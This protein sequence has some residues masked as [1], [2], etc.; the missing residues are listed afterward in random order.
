MMD[1]KKQL[2]SF[3]QKTK[4]AII[5]AEEQKDKEYL[6]MLWGG[7]LNGMKLSGYISRED[8]QKMFT[9]LEEFSHTAA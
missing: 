2:Q 1:K 8:Y 6:L 4:Q 5:E 7:F 9:E 3:L